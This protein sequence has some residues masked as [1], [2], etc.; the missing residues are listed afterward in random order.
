MF[1]DLLRSIFEDLVGEHGLTKMTKVAAVTICMAI[2]GGASGYL[3][4]MNVIPDDN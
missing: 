4:S 2:V 1:E 3:V